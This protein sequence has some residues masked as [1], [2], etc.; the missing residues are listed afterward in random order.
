MKKRCS[1]CQPNEILTRAALLD[2]VT[3]MHLAGCLTPMRIERQPDWESRRVVNNVFVAFF[4]TGLIR[5]I[6]EHLSVPWYLTVTFDRYIFYGTIPL[7]ILQIKEFSFIKVAKLYP[8]VTLSKMSPREELPTTVNAC[9]FR[10]Q[11]FSS[12]SPIDRFGFIH[13]SFSNSAELPTSHRTWSR[14]RGK[15]SRRLSKWKDFPLVQTKRPRWLQ[16]W[17]GWELVPSPGRTWDYNRDWS[18]THSRDGFGSHRCSR[19]TY[20]HS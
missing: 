3:V 7:G 16:C 17:I 11:K 8:Y 5:L 14:Q 1:S 6:S 20:S 10:F 13:F 15:S 9:N 4:K 18:T 2:C 12:S 19:A